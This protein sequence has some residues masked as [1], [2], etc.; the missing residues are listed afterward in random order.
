MLGYALGAAVDHVWLATNGK[1]T[2][3][4]IK[5]ARMAQKGIIGCRL[6]QTQFHDPIDD[7]VIHAFQD[8]RG[9]R[10]DPDNRDHREVAGYIQPENLVPK[11]RYAGNEGSDHCGCDGDAFVRPDG[12]VYQ[13]GC[14]D[15]IHVGNVFDGFESRGPDGDWVC[16]REVA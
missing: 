4:A 11:G 7:R 3:T 5:L 2:D 15:S 14:P 13:C 16:F 1:K 10:F 8:D 12:E 9:S 6:S